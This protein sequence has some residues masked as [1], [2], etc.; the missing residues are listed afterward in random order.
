MTTPPDG[1]DH[2]PLTHAVIGAAIEVRKKVGSGLLESAYHTFLC[3]E[4]RRAGLSFQSQPRMPV[5]YDGERVDI[6]FRPDLIV[7]GQVIVELKT[8]TA[9]VPAHEAQMITYVRLSGIHTG[10]LINFH[11]V[12][13]KKGV[14]RYSL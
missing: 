5:I 8:V 2:D 11:A 10:L 14:K 3:I 4:M 12:P 7:E 6:A 13:F 9:F 1:H